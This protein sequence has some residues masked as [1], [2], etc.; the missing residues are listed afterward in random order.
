MIIKKSNNYKVEAF[1]DRE[2]KLWVA[3]SEDVPGLVTE[4]KTIDILSNKLRQII[5]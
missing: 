2:A 4:A 1:W 3:T 5:P